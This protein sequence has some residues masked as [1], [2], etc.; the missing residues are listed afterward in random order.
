MPS[1]FLRGTDRTPLLSLSYAREGTAR[2]SSPSCP[3]RIKCTACATTKLSP[4]EARLLVLTYVYH[5]TIGVKLLPFVLLKLESCMASHLP[6][7]HPI[8]PGENDARAAADDGYLTPP[9]RSVTSLS[10]HVCCSTSA[11]CHHPASGWT[12]TQPWTP[13]FAPARTLS[14]RG[15]GDRLEASRPTG[16]PSPKNRPNSTTKRNLRN[17]G[18][19]VW[20]R[21]PPMTSLRA[22]CA[23]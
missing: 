23:S 8:F 16:H 6:A 17:L 14:S 7:W 13:G 22:K 18:E 15:E 21:S 4:H 3:C 20:F 11:R 2:W 19:C 9:L 5:P 12:P 10:R 1:V